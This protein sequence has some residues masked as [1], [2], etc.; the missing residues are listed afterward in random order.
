M[1]RPQKMNRNTASL[2]AGFAA[3]VLG[4][5]PA[6]SE[7]EELG[8]V[9]DDGKLDDDKKW[10]CWVNCE[11]VVYGLY[12]QRKCLS[13]GQLVSAGFC[14]GSCAVYLTGSRVTF[15]SRFLPHYL[16]FAWLIL[17]LEHRASKRHSPFGKPCIVLLL[18][19][20]LVEMARS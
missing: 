13:H 11:I 12:N 3:Y 10:L 19:T 17:T 15:I 18:A 1:P 8:C 5:R 2:V 16:S 4:Y 7:E 6:R 20:L 14:S 9:K